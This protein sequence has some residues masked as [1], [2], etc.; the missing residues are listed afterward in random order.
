MSSALSTTISASAAAPSSSNACATTAFSEFP[1]KDAACAVG[2]TSGYPDNY[3]DILKSCCKNAPV[4]SWGNGCA[5]YCLSVDQS[6]A[7]LQKCWQETDGGVKPGDIFCNGVQNAT[8]T[9]TPSKT[10]GGG[11]KET[12]GPSGSTNSPGAAY[13]VVPQ[14]PTKTGLGVLAVVLGSAVF[15]ALL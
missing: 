2:G 8:A 14:R 5:L 11:A 10:S 1:V 3:K 7:D 13:A 6:I 15:G 12:G 4:E 9:S